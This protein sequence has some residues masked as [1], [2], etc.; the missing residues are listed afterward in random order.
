MSASMRALSPTTSTSFVTIVPLNFASMRTVPAKVSFPSN[1]APAPRRRSPAPL[2]LGTGSLRFEMDMGLPSGRCSSLLFQNAIGPLAAGVTSPARARLDT[3]RRAGIHR[4]GRR[5]PR[6]RCARAHS[7]GWAWLRARR[8]A[9]SGGLR[10]VAAEPLGLV[11]QRAQLG[12]RLAGAIALLLRAVQQAQRLREVEV[13]GAAIGEERVEPAHPLLQLLED[14]V[15]RLLLGAADV[16]GLRVAASK[17][18]ASTSTKSFAA[19]ARS[20]SRSCVENA[21]SAE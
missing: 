13:A 10:D 20:G 4:M 9:G 8:C 12:A 5:T 16:V 15:H 18:K 1:S 3:P 7:P 21:R 19:R 14:V 6:T 2:A 17:R 11:E